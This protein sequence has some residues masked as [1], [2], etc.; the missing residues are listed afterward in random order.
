M[1]FSSL[2]SASK[3]Q[4][5]KLNIVDK[6][7]MRVGVNGDSVAPMESHDNLGEVGLNSIDWAA[8]TMMMK[9]AKRSED[10][11]LLRCCFVMVALFLSRL[12]RLV[13]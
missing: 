10:D 7:G 4:P 9:S 11:V 12:Y 5:P 3:K 6:L 1:T 8:P 2:F 13:M